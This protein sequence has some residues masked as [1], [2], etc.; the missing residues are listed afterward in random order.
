MSEEEKF[1]ALIRSRFSEKE[2]L[3]DEENWEKAEAMI[4][5][6]KRKKSAIKWSAIFLL[7]L[8]AGVALMLPFTKWTNPSSG[9]F[10]G[11]RNEKSVNEIAELNDKVKTGSEIAEIRKEEHEN[12]SEKSPSDKSKENKN[13]V[14]QQPAKKQ[15]HKNEEIQSDEKELSNLNK[16][17]KAVADISHPELKTE[18]YPKEKMLASNESNE[19]ASGVKKE[20]QV[21]TNQIPPPEEQTHK[22]E[23]KETKAADEI[24]QNTFTDNNI[25]EENIHKN[26]SSPAPKESAVTTQTIQPD[27]SFV[28]SHPINQISVLQTEKKNDSVNKPSLV[29]VITP[30]AKDSV[31]LVPDPPAEASAQAGSSVVVSQ[32]NSVAQPVAQSLTSATIFSLDAGTNY[33]MGWSYND[34]TEGRGFNPVFGIAITHYFNPKWSLY[35]GI[36]YGS[37]AHL[38][39]SQKTFSSTTFDFGYNSVDTIVDTK[40]LYYAV[41]P[42]QFHYHFNNKNSIGIGGSVSYLVNTKSN[43]IINNMSGASSAP[44]VTQKTEIGYYAGVFNQWDASLA[45]AYRRRISEKFSIS[46]SANYGLID[47]K[48]NSFFS[49]DKFERN[50]GFKLILSYNLFD[51]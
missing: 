37:I 24:L 43:V 6:S 39:A 3:F 44:T 4:D 10:A 31:K 51:F 35:S 25:V 26:S 38:K 42:I 27:S 21:I 34:T 47:I 41:L 29:S 33:E 2:F 14:S 50:I 11:N 23:L 30:P 17:Q 18:N 49:R 48:S 12:F 15:T 19:N 28:Q 46:A 20:S 45:V 9:G 40:L 7:G 22:K 13:I 16:N 36:Q 1:D 32:N 5:S 8:F